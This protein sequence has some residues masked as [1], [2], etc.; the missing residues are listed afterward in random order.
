MKVAHV[1]SSPAAGGAEIYVKDLAKALSDE[2]VV[3]YI[4]FL[5]HAADVGRS[6]EFEN[7][8]L[9]ELTDLNIEYFFIG[10]EV[11]RNPLLGAM[12]I[13]K[14]VKENS[15][16]LYHSH[17]TY[18]ILSGAFL[19]IPRLYTHHSCNI[20][21]SRFFQ[22]G[23]DLLLEQYIGI[24]KICTENLSQYVSKPVVTIKNGVSV[25]RLHRSTIKRKP[26]MEIMHCLAIGRI[27]EQKNYSLLIDSISLLPEGIKNFIKVSI[28]GEGEEQ[29]KQLLQER[30][31]RLGLN[32]VVNFIGNRSDIPDLLKNADLFLMTSAWEG[33]PIALIEATLCGLPCIVT[34][35]GGCSEVI[36]T[37]K[38]GFLVEPENP[39]AFAAAFEELF[40]NSDLYSEF[41]NNALN[42][43]KTFTI[44]SAGKAH[45]EIYSELQNRKY[46]L[47]KQHHGRK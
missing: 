4:C 24:S 9:S 14:F 41:S 21:V 36:E 2:G 18:G 30:I 31:D 40:G 32:G 3:V 11:R 8:F 15:V 25:S 47:E 45:S 10:Y 43:S 19:N 44:E 17:L 28:A 27:T 13:R 34:N 5:N 12:R 1:I 16:D 39:Q 37:C 42:N 38:N 22:R 7:K 23:L 6:S 20:R 33:L 26:P 29:Q 46:N 35:V